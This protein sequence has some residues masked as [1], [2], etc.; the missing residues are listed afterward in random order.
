MARRYYGRHDTGHPGAIAPS[1]RPVYH[2][3]IVDS[4]TRGGSPLHLQSLHLT[5]FKTFAPPTVIEF[6][7]GITAVIGANGSGKSNLV[8]AMRWVLGEQSMRGLRSRRSEDVIFSG[9]ARRRPAAMA[10][11][12][13]RFDNQGGWLRNPKSEVELIR[14][15]Y[16]SGEG[17][18]LING[19]RVRLRDVVDLAREGAL[20]AGDHTIVGQG[21]V[22]AV[23]SL[24]GIERRGFIATVGGMAPYEARRAEALQRLSQTRDNVAG[25]QIVYD[26]MEP[27]LRLLRRQANIALN[28]LAAQE[29]LTN[30]L[31]GHYAQAWRSLTD[32][33]QDA[34]RKGLEIEALVQD[35]RTRIDALDAERQALRSR[36]E[37]VRETRQAARDQVMAAEYSYKRAADAHRAASDAQTRHAAR[38]L[39]L[40]TSLERF[41]DAS[42]VNDALIQTESEIQGL[43]ARSREIEGVILQQERRTG[44]LKTRE[45][46]L[47]S[48]R[49]GLASSTVRLHDA[50]RQSEITIDRLE[51]EI[52][53]VRHGLHET[54][55]TLPLLLLDR[56]HRADEQRRMKEAL[57]EAESGLVA[58]RASLQ[59]AAQDAAAA[60]SALTDAA[61]A[62]DGATRAIDSTKLRRDDLLALRPPGDG[63]QTVIESLRIPVHLGP[64]I[65]AALGDLTEAASVPAED[66]PGPKAAPLPSVRWREDVRNRLERENLSVEGWLLDL[67]E[68]NEGDAPV[69][70]LLAA[71]LV[72]GE[73]ADIERAWDMV[74][75]VGALKVG[76]PALRLVDQAGAL[77]TAGTRLLAGSAARQSVR[78]E[79]ALLQLEEE[80]RKLQTALERIEA[81]C[82]KAESSVAENRTQLAS[83]QAAFQ[84][85]TTAVTSAR[86]CGEQSQHRLESLQSEIERAETRLESLAQQQDSLQADLAHEEDQLGGIREEGRVAENSLTALEGE[87]TAHHS[88]MNRSM[89]LARD[90]ENERLLLHRRMEIETR[91]RERL[92]AVQA[93]AE[94]ERTHSIALLSQAESAAQKVDA[95][96][97]KARLDLERA[98]EALQE[99]RR[100]LD[101]AP[102]D[103]ADDLS[104][105]RGSSHQEL[106]Q[107]LETA[108]AAAQKVRSTAG[109]LRDSIS[110]LVEDC[111]IDLGR[112]P[113]T[114]QAPN[115]LVTL[116]DLDIRRLRVK[117]E[118]A[119]D[120]D[121]GVTREYEE[122]AARRD[123]LRDQMDDLNLAI[124][125]LE[126]M[127]R[128]ADREV[129]RRFRVA[130]SHVNG[131]F[132]RFFQEI[133]GGGS[134]EL[135]LETVEDVESVEIKVQL[136][137]KRAR[138][139]SGLSGGERT[140]VAGA[141]LFSLIAAAPPPFC[142]LDEVDA[143]L[144]ETNVDRY[145]AVL[146]DLARETQFIVVTHNRAT[147]AAANSLYGIVLD[148]EGVSKALSL[149][150]DEAVAG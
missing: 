65:A 96:V 46:D 126:G 58:T 77:R 127:L 102:D 31:E 41:E 98:E 74:A 135:R 112:H 115:P 75:G 56:S 136:P 24:R 114:L 131:L 142:V 18:Y 14:R 116:T 51:L 140:L 111:N 60:Q 106:H 78:R 149:R 84:E 49:D 137:G 23:L 59:K 92:R 76:Y 71:T 20:A 107:A 117:A 97:R 69:R 85:A 118:Q 119:A 83:A 128:D 67:I 44:A 143:A 88:A 86:S 50:V 39:D 40:R 62:R 80:L 90:I 147:M 37:V 144:D 3:V 94:E 53:R 5:G 57:K 1:V 133:F 148:S 81:D 150:L 139:L 134:A 100:G 10:E 125:D 123:A 63:R 32:Q 17:E 129:R 146:H 109:H 2:E 34:E 52:E 28:A 43:E 91:E 12:C 145:L 30:A 4:L 36:L 113:A 29:Q 9:S 61:S 33:L 16:R 79:T 104:R 138:D 70:A 141:F 54:E 95:S 121:P 130:F 66:E 82:A 15:V 7:E 89:D 72:L 19:N 11:V 6:S 108:I 55:R 25:A 132:G 120:V 87:L 38:T 47:H 48:L 101:A 124:E 103:P 110:R 105:F 22:D 13:V 68:S 73:G 21:M 122:L 64:A 93:A 35:L 42:T 45:R 27:R 8:D 26:E 99:A